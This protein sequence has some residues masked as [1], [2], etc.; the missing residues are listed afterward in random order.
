MTAIAVFDRG[1]AVQRP[2]VSAGGVAK[3]WGLAESRSATGSARPEP[4]RH[5]QFPPPTLESV[6]VPRDP[7]D[8]AR[9]RVALAQLA[10]QD[11]LI[12]VRQDDGRQEIS[13]SLY[14]EVQKEVIQAT[15]ASDFGLDVTFR[16]T[17]PLYVERPVAPGEAIE[18]LQAESN[19]FLATIGLRVEPAPAGSGIDF[20]LEV[21]VR[22]TPLFV[23]KT[24]ESFGESMARVRARGAAGGPPRLAGH[25]LH[26]DD[27]RLHVQRP[28]RPAVETRAAQHGG[29]LPKADADRPHASPRGRRDGRLRARRPREPRDPGGRDRRRHAR[30]GAVRCRYRVAGAGGELCMI[31]LVLPAARAHDLQRRLAGL[32]G[33]E[34]VLESSF[35]GHQPVSGE[36]PSRRRTTPNPL[37]LGEYLAHGG[38]RAS[39]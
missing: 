1:P 27:D 5:T 33:G 30:V 28:R 8:K 19:P 14:G 10:E 11:P 17:T 16:E 13:V 25:R 6:V 9:L 34:G 35:A 29:R 22:A 12:D 4:R 31:E 2:A 20:R 37:N 39:S 32:T 24:L 15:L 3:L 23:Y 18:I 21:D 36:Q 26:R 7:D 38:R